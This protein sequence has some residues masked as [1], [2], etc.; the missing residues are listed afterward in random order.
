MSLTPY[1]YWAQ[2]HHELYLRVELSDVQ[3]PDITIADNVL[4]FKAQG[5]G[6]KGVNTY[7]FS[8][9]FFEPV[10]NKFVQKLTQRQV[11]ITVRKC[12]KD[13]WS[14]LT[15]QE[16]KP[17][18][19]APDFDRW[20][21]ESDAEMELRKKEEERITKIR[22]ESKLREDPFLYLKRGYLFMYNLVQFLGF[23]WIFVNM[24]VRLFIFGQDS[25]YDTFN[26]MA[27]MMYFCQILAFLEI[28]NPLIGWVRTAVKP[29]LI[30]VLGRNFILF[31]IFGQLN[32]MQTKGVVFFVFYLWSSIE[33]IRYPFYMLACIDTDWKLLTWIRYTIWIP[34]Y[35]LGTLAEAVSVI[36]AM[37]IFNE[38]GIFS[39][40]V[41]PFEF[42]ISFSVF[43]NVYL[44]LTL[45][46]VAINFR[47]MYKQ[48]RRRLGSKKR[49]ML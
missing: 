44:V 18:F 38:T 40:R 37:P 4:H 24:T 45:F 11:G 46:G 14:R 10:N 8:L 1:V 32:E 29:A 39:I 12:K 25:F 9:E 43:L 31:V 16:R 28:V 7:E 17:V 33:I 19:V 30:Q 15:K 6:A 13:W 41:F 47:H 36:Q 35:P 20:L 49:K 26:T 21:D 3:N 27:D 42:T 5:H 48:R 2:R 34:L 22:T 23:S